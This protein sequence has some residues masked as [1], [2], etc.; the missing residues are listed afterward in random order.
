MLSGRK[1]NRD[2]IAFANNATRQYNSHNASFSDKIARFISVQHS[3]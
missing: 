3:V 2:R 1:A